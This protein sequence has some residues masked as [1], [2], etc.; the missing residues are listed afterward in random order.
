[1][2]TNNMYYVTGILFILHETL[3]E[4]HVRM[5]AVNYLKLTILIWQISII[6]LH[7]DPV[8]KKCNNIVYFICFPCR[9]Y[10]GSTRAWEHRW[11]ELHPFLLSASLGS[12]SARPSSRNTQM[13]CYRKL[14]TSLSSAPMLVMHSISSDGQ[15]WGQIHWNV[16]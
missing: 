1:M 5:F 11:W 4:V 15:T 7:D 9:V 13:M 14:C 12:M 16:F 6:K 2:C 3:S 10:V 8:V